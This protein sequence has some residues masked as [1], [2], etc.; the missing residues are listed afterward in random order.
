[1]GYSRNNPFVITP[2]LENHPI[3]Y[4]ESTAPWVGY[5]APAGST[6]WQQGLF[7]EIATPAPGGY[8]EKK[9]YY[10]QDGK[11][12][13]VP[14]D[15][16]LALDVSFPRL[17]Q[18][19]R[20]GSNLQQY[21]R[22]NTRLFW[23]NP[24]RVA[25]VKE[26]VDNMPEGEQ[27]P[28]WLDVDKLKVLY[29]YLDF[30]NPNKPYDQWAPLTE[31]DPAYS[32]LY[33]IPN[34]PQDIVSPYERD[35]VYAANK[36]L[37]DYKDRYNPEKTE[38]AVKSLMESRGIT[39]EDAQTQVYQELT[40]DF[41][42]L[43]PYQQLLLAIQSMTPQDSNAPDWAKN[44]SLGTSVA[45]TGVASFGIT[46][47]LVGGISFLSTVAGGAAIG[48][49]VGLI[50]AAGVSIP[51]M[52]A[53]AVAIKR[54]D[55]VTANK[56]MALWNKPAEF[57]EKT[58]GSIE[59]G[60][61]LREMGINP[62]NYDAKA[63]FDAGKAYYESS[64]Y[65]IG[66]FE[67]NAV[68]AIAHKLDKDWSSGKQAGY[69]QVWQFQKGI[70]EPQAIREGYLV[71]APLAEAVIRMSSGEP[72]EAVYW[73]MVD[74][75]GYSGTRADYHAQSWID[76]M[77]YVPFMSSV[78]GEKIAGTLNEPRLAAAFRDARGN[79][80]LDALPGS[81]QMPLSFIFNQHNRLGAK[82][83]WKAWTLN[84]SKGFIDVLNNYSVG[85]R[86][87]TF[88]DGLPITAYGVDQMSTLGKFLAGID[89]ATGMPKKGSVDIHSPAYQLA[90]GWSKLLMATPEGTIQRNLDMLDSA[91]VYIRG[92]STDPEDFMLHARRLI[93]GANYVKD[94]PN[95]PMAYAYDSPTARSVRV[96][97][98]KAIQGDSV[99]TLEKLWDLSKGVRSQIKSVSDATGITPAKLIDMMKKG[100][101]T[102][103]VSK[104]NRD[105]AP[106]NYLK[107][108]TAEG[109]KKT[110]RS[111]IKNDIP[112]YPELMTAKI[113]D[114]IM[115]SVA[116][117]YSKAYGIDVTQSTKLAKWLGLNKSVMSLAFLNTPGFTI[118]NLLNN[119][120]TMGYDGVGS[121]FT[122]RYSYDVAKKYGVDMP[123]TI[124][125]GFGPAGRLP[126]DT[127]SPK[128]LVDYLQTNVVNNV[129]KL[130]IF[131]RLAGNIEGSAKMAAFSTGMDQDFNIV[132]KNGRPQMPEALRIELAQAGVNPEIVHAMLGSATKASDIDAIL[133]D[134]TDPLI[135]QATLR[136]LNARVDIDG[137][138]TAALSNLGLNEV[139]SRDMVTKLAIADSVM[140]YV[141]EEGMTPDLALS[142]VY[143]DL[144]NKAIAGYAE[145][146][147]DAYA[148][149]SQDLD[150]GGFGAMATV[151]DD[152]VAGNYLH[153]MD[154]AYDLADMTAEATLIRKNNPGRGGQELANSIYNMRYDQMVEKTQFYLQEFLEKTLAVVHRLKP[155][156]PVEA[157]LSD[158]LL[159]RAA[160]I[161]E[162][163]MFVLEENNKFFEPDSKL[164]YHRDVQPRVRQGQQDYADRIEALN[165]QIDEQFVKMF[166][167]DG[168][169]KRRAEGWVANNKELR[170]RLAEISKN[171]FNR[172]G[173]LDE[174][175][176]RV[177]W[178]EAL[179][180]KQTIIAEFTAK[181][182][183]SGEALNQALRRA[184]TE[185]RRVGDQPPEVP[186]IPGAT[187]TRPASTRPPEPEYPDDDWQ[188]R[189]MN[190]PK[191][192]EYPDNRPYEGRDRI[193]DRLRLDSNK[194]RFEEM[195]DP[196]FNRA[197]AEARAI[198]AKYI[199]GW[200]NRNSAELVMVRRQIEKTFSMTEAEAQM[201]LGMLAH[202][203]E[204]FAFR[205]GKMDPMDYIRRYKFESVT[206][207]ELQTRANDLGL[208]SAG[209][210]AVDFDPR[211]AK[212]IIK[213]SKSAN[214]TSLFHEL[215]HTWIFD[216]DHGDM[217]SLNELFRYGTVEELYSNHR[218]WLTGRNSAGENFDD[219]AFG[220]YATRS[221]RVV[222]IA[223]EYFYQRGAFKGQYGKGVSGLMQRFRNYV[224]DV[225]KKYRSTWDLPGG[226]H[227]GDYWKHESW[228]KNNTIS[229]EVE[230]ALNR[231]FE[232]YRQ[233]KVWKPGEALRRTPTLAKKFGDIFRI[234]NSGEF[235][236]YKISQ[237]EQQIYTD[238]LAEQ[239]Y[240][241]VL[242]AQGLQEFKD[243]DG[244]LD[245]PYDLEHK[246]PEFPPELKHL[247]GHPGEEPMPYIERRSELSLLGSYIFDVDNSVISRTNEI[248]SRLLNKVASL[249]EADAIE[250]QRL[251]YE[252][253]Y[254][255][256][257]NTQAVFDKDEI[258]SYANK[259]IYWNSFR[260]TE[261]YGLSEAQLTKLHDNYID[262]ARSM[263]P[264]VMEAAEVNFGRMRDL[265]LL[266]TQSANLY[267]RILNNNIP[268]WIEPKYKTY[269]ANDPIVYKQTTGQIQTLRGLKDIITGHH[270][271]IM[272]DGVSYYPKW[273][274]PDP[275]RIAL[276]PEKYGLELTR[277]ETA[278]VATPTSTEP[279][280]LGDW[281]ITDDPDI[282]SKREVPIKRFD[283]TKKYTYTDYM[284]TSMKD[285]PEGHARLMQDSVNKLLISTED[286]VT[287]D[288]PLTFK[289]PFEG[290]KSLESIPSAE[291]DIALKDILFGKLKEK[292][293]PNQLAVLGAMID[294]V[295]A[296]GNNVI[297]LRTG[298]VGSWL[299]KV[300]E[301]K[302]KWLD[303]LLAA[304]QIG[305]YTWNHNKDSWALRQA[306]DPDNI[307]KAYK[308][309]HAEIDKLAIISKRRN[310]SDA[311]TD[312]IYAEFN[313]VLIAYR[314][315]IGQ[316]IPFLKSTAPSYIS[317]QTSGSIKPSVRTPYEMDY[318]DPA[319]WNATDAGQFSGSYRQKFDEGVYTDDPDARALSTADRAPWEG[320]WWN[321]I[322]GLKDATMDELD[323]EVRRFKPK[324]E[325]EQTPDMEA[326]D[327][328]VN[329]GNR[330]S[331]ESIMDNYQSLSEVDLRSNTKVT[332]EQILELEKIAAAEGALEEPLQT[333]V[334]PAN[335]ILEE[336]IRL[337]DEYVRKLNANDPWPESIIELPETK[338]IPIS[339]EELKALRKKEIELEKVAKANIEIENEYHMRALADLA[340]QDAWNPIK[341]AETDPVVKASLERE[342][343][344]I[345]GVVKYEKDVKTHKT[346]TTEREYRVAEHEILYGMADAYY[347]WAQLHGGKL[348]DV[349]NDEFVTFMQRRVFPTL[350][351]DY[352]DKKGSVY[353]DSLNFRLEYLMN[354]DYQMLKQRGYVDAVEYNRSTG[355]YIDWNEMVLEKEGYVS[356]ANIPVTQF[357]PLPTKL[358][359]FGN[360]FWKAF[361]EGDLQ[362]RRNVS[363][364]ALNIAKS[365]INRNSTRL[366]DAGDLVALLFPQHGRY[367]IDESQRN[368]MHKFANSIY[369]LATEGN[370]SYTEEIRARGLLTIEEPGQ[371]YMY[372]PARTPNKPLA[373]DGRFMEGNAYLSNGRSLKEAYQID[374]KGYENAKD[375]A[376]QGPKKG[377]PHEGDD[378]AQ[379]Y[380]VYK[381]L[382]KQYFEE[383]PELY[384][385]LLQR[386][387]EIPYINPN[388]EYAWNNSFVFNDLVNREKWE[389]TST[390]DTIR[391]KYAEAEQAPEQAPAPTPAPAPKPVTAPADPAT[392]ENTAS[393]QPMGP[394]NS[395]AAVPPPFPSNKALLD[396]LPDIKN[397]IEEMRSNLNGGGGSGIDPQTMNGL[398]PIG[399][400]QLHQYA[401]Q[402]RGALASAIQHAYDM[403]MI[404]ADNAL[405]N[406]ND[407]TGMDD[408]LDAIFPYQFWF[409]RS[410]VNWAKRAVNRPGILSQYA[411]RLVHMQRMGAHM[412]KVPLRLQGKMQI[413]WPFAEEW[414]G[415]NV[416]INPFTDLMPVNQI[417]SPLE[418]MAQ[419]NI[420]DPTNELKRQLNEKNITQEQYDEA[421]E[422]Q[423]GDVWDAAY[424]VTLE[425]VKNDA[426]PIDLAAMMLS[427]NW[428]ITE[429]LNFIRKTPDRNWPGTNMGFTLE[430]HGNRI[431][432]SGY[433]MVGD[434]LITAG[435]ILEKPEKIVRGERFVYYGEFGTY[436]V[437]RELANMAA[438][439]KN[440]Q[441]CIKAM[442]EQ[443]GDLWDEANR[444]VMDQISLKTPGSLFVQSVEEGDF[445]SLPIALLITMFPGGIFPE[446]ELK[447]RGLSE[448]FNQMWTKAGEGDTTW[449]ADWFNENPEYLARS[450]I[451]DSPRLM[452]KKFLLNQI[453]DYYTSQDAKNKVL[454]KEHLGKEFIDGILSGDG[455]DYEALDLEQLTRWAR[456]AKGVVP[457]T[458]DTAGMQ[459]ALPDKDMPVMYDEQQLLQLNVYFDE[460]NR[461]YP[462]QSWQNKAYHNLTT[463]R[464]KNI[465]LAKYP[466]LKQYWEWNKAYQTQA[467]VVKE[468][469]TRNVTET[470]E[471]IDPYYGVSKELVDG[472]RAEK[473]RLFPN[474]QWLNAEYFAI[475]SNNYQ[476]RRA[477]ISKYPELEQYWNWKSEIEAQSPQLKYYNAQMDAQFMEEN[478]FPVAPADMA[479]NKIAEALDAMG[480]NQYV[481][482][483]LL[484]YYVRGKPIPYGSL[485]YLKTMWEEAG[486]PDTLMEWIDNLF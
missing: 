293:T 211:S 107:K 250:A 263:G 310:Y 359:G 424:A 156:S 59:A 270:S 85:V 484:D 434:A 482:Q 460:R 475:P 450:A 438:E 418:Y 27:V 341:L 395:L 259:I 456:M 355:K 218:G 200:M 300:T 162:S 390:T 180:K 376:G 205:T 100:E 23:S 295:R 429:G 168:L 7:R 129:R 440:T 265:S 234:D 432:D 75:Y 104:I 32:M 1:M 76:P 231:M 45:K 197:M 225:M 22:A 193:G 228:L 109:L 232:G 122:T 317:F 2:P 301:F 203:A 289:H 98:T 358:E 54:G 409:T 396:M 165:V 336:G 297:A 158:L 147:A 351:K 126:G 329:R 240:R 467:P 364:L 403:G 383:N 391:A 176:R 194:L 454:F 185:G 452:M 179:R 321:E 146:A 433:Q 119:F 90:S 311:D 28:D 356:L 248:S 244:S 56:L 470:G 163:Q 153:V 320:E 331:A 91:F 479:P 327:A 220:E 25:R 357:T 361:T 77:Q 217:V 347:E 316:Y 373:K 216:L 199:N 103:I 142:R 276:D 419:K 241:K 55:E 130:A 171:A 82:R 38:W 73:D 444:R 280:F 12:Y 255:S 105:T 453:M 226:K 212:W 309:L 427:P 473:A 426:R 375:G 405:L 381:D 83:G 78:F 404:K 290:R 175:G 394:N 412:N 335:L 10:E 188:N 457:E 31:D 461:L 68:S 167:F 345:D 420:V 367:F 206:Q 264:E 247:F 362:A 35:P 277:V 8:I 298:E 238:A 422:N 61:Q 437:N 287:Y 443:K 99:Q 71:G 449:M 371:R 127:A 110:V 472:Y 485:S 186:D 166:E 227:T 204:D 41:N 279:E 284:S 81:I 235:V 65:G 120:V 95:D 13:Y 157:A 476:E 326:Y 42:K 480:L 253:A 324:Q 178:Q 5:Q 257:Y 47:S 213:A 370:K 307:A 486:K 344:F 172:L 392:L 474:S 468:W 128:T 385:E 124:T 195:P 469:L 415:D 445:T 408:W 333:P 386:R 189:P 435:K 380:K 72:E 368:L 291:I 67:A 464:E 382:W 313:K 190:Q 425:Q 436:I 455:V 66:N 112:Y 337:T 233:D 161:E 24:Q 268:Q 34:P 108:V 281:Y 363:D 87:Q 377:T 272:V 462:N 89:P 134:M 57:V 46:S 428:L 97:L 342:K 201:A 221:E 149:A 115:G 399:K 299:G 306:L 36:F 173:E 237:D 239:A 285:W 256:V 133:G 64:L 214:V 140:R 93:D 401:K 191:P 169:S 446:G 282:K 138:L 51:L 21:T 463:K 118:K 366:Y 340:K 215:I 315:A 181:G 319:V 4:P 40:A 6:P 465:F 372:E 332:R 131:T 348:P 19:A 121:M 74:R 139:A 102:E 346:K 471:A 451:N 350:F 365:L 252:E 210:A 242:K 174:A 481:S 417:L 143:D 398:S 86:N 117:T 442:I 14:L 378:V 303:P 198:H 397:L 312:L 353:Y 410:M 338:D 258:A 151:L 26:M 50:I 37:Q 223:E 352:A 330:Q 43:E 18:Y 273:N 208:R 292:K 52:I 421:M 101:Y 132:Y 448:S 441:D 116:D 402:T 80:A 170:R 222:K 29:D 431:K 379:S 261:L 183:E 125:K 314:E 308:E 349:Q 145:N 33:Q 278:P 62:Y 414:M 286:T 11:K 416:Y 155:D 407:R 20:Y 136:S 44:V 236:M 393:H 246:M 152:T 271:R 334:R 88:V 384:W 187:R 219:T 477:F 114:A 369:L 304:D 150:V 343:A 53:T 184:G 411:N 466:E 400:D 141:N 84:T 288:M 423:S 243:M 305:Y 251:F 123:D 267:D 406:Y 182:L 260:N 323:P 224:V 92:L 274:L 229:P 164:D 269:A 106:T 483:D 196:K 94:N 302:Q 137:A 430:S 113:A 262:A 17:S 318:T 254:N 328:E 354:I 3:Q 39:F 9:Y 374:Y 154:N 458:A 202:K 144:R 70:V 111:F 148:I 245:L 16:H 459:G 322:P 60:H 159:R 69:G 294:H 275:F 388:S 96:G 135:A 207:T 389:P 296:D 30:K 360:E 266:I 48:G 283:P 15:N 177:V 63:L 160:L 339:G 478:A 439:G 79:I 447:Q 192:G 49:P 387:A 413:P 249:P 58:L 209:T 230:R 325:F